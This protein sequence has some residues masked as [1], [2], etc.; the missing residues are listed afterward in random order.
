MLPKA[1]VAKGRVRRE[2]RRCRVVHAALHQKAIRA[3]L[4]LFVRRRGRRLRGCCCFAASLLR[5]GRAGL[6][7]CSLRRCRCCNRI[8]GRWPQPQ[9]CSCG[10][11]ITGVA[12]SAS[13][14][15][16]LRRKQLHLQ[17]QGRSR[18]SH[19]DIGM[20]TLKTLHGGFNLPL[21]IGKISKLKGARAVG[22]HTLR[23]L[24]TARRNLHASQLTPCKDNLAMQ[25][26]CV[27][28]LAH[29]SSATA[30][31]VAPHS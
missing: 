16:L 22:D 15:K 31:A 25:R 7:A 30:S 12:C 23:R 5:A 18:R 20:E 4:V 9:C 19:I 2:A 17:L 13:A 24:A 6:R 3:L 29:Q 21:A 14:A 8:A 26:A 10:L 1:Q 28:A 11:L 27:R